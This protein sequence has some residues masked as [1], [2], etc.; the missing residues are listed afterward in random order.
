MA[1][2]GYGGYVWSREPPPPERD[3][4]AQGL[5][6]GVAAGLT[7]GGA[8]WATGVRPDGSRP[9]D[10]IAR[11]ARTTGNLMPFQ[12]GN[13]FRVPELLSPYTSPQYQDLTKVSGPGGEE[14]W[15]GVWGKDYLQSQQTYKYLKQLTGKTDDELLDLG[16]RPGMSGDDAAQEIV[17][18]RTAGSA[19]GKLYTRMKDGRKLLASD[20]V[21]L[22]QFTGESPDLSGIFDRQSKLNRAF[23]GSMQAMDM[24]VQEVPVLTVHLT[25][26]EKLRTSDNTKY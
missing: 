12:L 11:V 15:R 24:W 16:I 4:R 10:T 19:K 23:F 26:E 21:I 25:R 5:S 2:E 9:I 6:L 20:N 8:L 14:L 3:W 22:K 7:V 13:T 17:F 18:E 1:F